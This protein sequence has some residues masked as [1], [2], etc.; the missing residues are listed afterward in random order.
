[1]QEIWKK[2]QCIDKPRYKQAG[3]SKL[4]IIFW[5]KQAFQ[6]KNI[7]SKRCF[8]GERKRVK[9]VLQFWQAVKGSEKANKYNN[10][11]VQQRG[12]RERANKLHKPVQ[13][14][15]TRKNG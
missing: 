4:L 11:A 10:I 14:V 5:P 1:M 2:V 3:L 7:L 6:I 13:T 8:Y 15:V 9:W 12:E